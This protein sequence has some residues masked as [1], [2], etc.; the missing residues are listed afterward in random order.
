MGRQDCYRR[1]R[2]EITTLTPQGEERNIRIALG[3]NDGDFDDLDD[4]D[5]EDEEDEFDDEDDEDAD[6]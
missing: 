5:F 1:G 3:Y 4:D 6:Y 2:F